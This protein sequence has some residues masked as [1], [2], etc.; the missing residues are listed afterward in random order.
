MAES[1]REKEGG[2]APV[3]PGA[4]SEDVQNVQVGESVVVDGSLLIGLKE[5]VG[6][7]PR[8]CEMDDLAWGGPRSLYLAAAAAAAANLGTRSTYVVPKRGRESSCSVTEFFF[9]TSSNHSFRYVQYLR[10]LTSGMR[11]LPTYP[12]PDISLTKEKK[13]KNTGHIRT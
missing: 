10:Y 4:P 3:P 9:P 5:G 12:T 8:A 13:K 6:G 7:H 1:G 2:V 11:Y